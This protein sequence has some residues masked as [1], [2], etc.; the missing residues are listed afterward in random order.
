MT[1]WKNNPFYYEEEPLILH[2]KLEAYFGQ[3]CFEVHYPEM[4][5]ASLVHRT[6]LE[7]RV[8]QGARHS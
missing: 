3:L 7:Q 1:E 6:Y 4:K 2:N 5:H 8:D